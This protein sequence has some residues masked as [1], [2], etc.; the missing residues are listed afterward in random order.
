MN[1]RNPLLGDLEIEVVALDADESS[2]SPDTGHAGAS[3]THGEIKHKV[4][5]IGVET[6][7]ILEQALRLL[8]R[9]VRLAPAR[10]VTILGAREH[11][12]DVLHSPRQ[13]EGLI[14]PFDR[15]RM[16]YKQQNIF[17]DI[18]ARHAA[19]ERIGDVWLEPMKALTEPHIR[20][21]GRNQS[22]GERLLSKQ[23]HVRLWPGEIPDQVERACNGE[24]NV[25]FVLLSDYQPAVRSV[26]GNRIHA[27]H[28]SVGGIRKNCVEFDALCDEF[29]RDFKAVAVKK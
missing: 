15:L 4:S 9:V 27:L 28:N 10:C 11:V 2:A 13:I 20:V 12:L 19:V 22:G 25:P 18:L 7:Q 23:K 24:R 26:S 1:L 16:G 29:P 17:H 21:L 14:L 3:G 5:G 8:C 6:E